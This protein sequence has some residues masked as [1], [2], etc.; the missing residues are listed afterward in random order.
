MVNN[1]SYSFSQYRYNIIIILLEA[2]SDK[3]KFVVEPK[4]K[5]KTLNVNKSTEKSVDNNNNSKAASK[6]MI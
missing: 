1:S 3:P 2:A 5:M 6:K 4:L